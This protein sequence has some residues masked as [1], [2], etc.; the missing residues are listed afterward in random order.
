MHF[1]ILFFLYVTLGIFGKFSSQ[2][3]RAS[4][5]FGHELL[6]RLYTMYILKVRHRYTSSLTR[7]FRVY[8]VRGAWLAVT[9]CE[10]AGGRHDCVR[11]LLAAAARVHYSH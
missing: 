7:W 5:P 6:H 3:T 9:G 4:S 11:H 8:V 1:R 10:D 2:R